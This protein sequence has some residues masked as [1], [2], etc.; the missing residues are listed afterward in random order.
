MS[1][2]PRSGRHADALKNH[3]EFGYR[4]ETLAELYWRIVFDLAIT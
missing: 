4:V 2:L 1:D 3:L